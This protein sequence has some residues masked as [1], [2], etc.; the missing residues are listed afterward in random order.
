MIS[1]GICGGISVIMILNQYAFPAYLLSSLIAVKIMIWIVFGGV[2][3]MKKNCLYL[4]VLILSSLCLLFSSATCMAAE[5]VWC[6]VNKI[7]LDSSEST[8]QRFPQPGAPD[9]VIG[10]SYAAL[11]NL[12]LAAYGGNIISGTEYSVHQWD[13]GSGDYIGQLALS[14]SPQQHI[15]DPI[16]SIGVASNGD[17]LIS[18]AGGIYDGHSNPFPF[19][20]ARYDT[21]GN[22]V[23]N[24]S[25]ANLFILKGSPAASADAVF[26][27]SQYII[28]VEYHED[29]Q[30]FATDGTYVGAFGS[31]CGGVVGGIAVSGN[32]LYALDYGDGLRVYTLN[33]TSMPTYSHLITLPGTVNPAASF[34]GGDKLV[35]HGNALY[36]SDSADMA[37]YK[38]DFSGNLL[39]TYTVSPGG[40]LTILG[41]LTVVEVIPPTPTATATSTATPSFTPTDTP[42]NTPTPTHTPSNT[43]TPT[44]TATNVVPQ[45]F[46]D[47]NPTTGAPGLLVGMVGSATDQDGYITAFAWDILGNG[48]LGETIEVEGNPTN[49]IIS[50]SHTY[51]EPGLSYPAF[52]VWDDKNESSFAS[53]P[54]F[55]VPPIPT[56]TAT[57][58]PTPTATSTGTITPQPTATPTATSTGT[59]TPQPTATPTATSTGTITP[60]PTATST[61]TPTGTITPPPTATS[62]PT[63]TPV[64]TST[65]T[66]TPNWT[67]THTH[68][69]T[70]TFTP[71]PIASFDLNGDY[72][73]DKLDLLL[74][75]DAMGTASPQMDFDQNGIVDMA[76]V[77][78]LALEWNRLLPTP[79][80]TYTPSWTPTATYTHTPTDTPTPTPTYAIIP[81]LALQQAVRDAINKQTGDLTQQDLESLIE[82]AAFQKGIQRLEGLQYC[83]N[84]ERLSVWGNSI[85]D[86]G[87]LG[88]LNALQQ[89]FLQENQIIDLQPLVDNTGLGSGDVINIKDNPLSMTA[90]QVQVPALRGRGVTV[91]TE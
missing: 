68:T 48:E 45:V 28:G 2:N 60:Q 85:S 62:T 77:L 22:W 4:R 23:V 26:V 30:M 56:H 89:L 34:F 76:D 1:T 29:I 39:A 72:R 54:L 41:G 44:Q 32:V 14:P 35:S 21:S 7:S 53:R 87:P 42:T 79:T 38:L 25:H 81:D 82:L 63:D 90:Q 75:I 69:P 74:I 51:F 20:V 88:S 15:I 70:L 17:L 46:L 19:P 49:V 52:Y 13:G 65:S 6:S 66:P 24:Y 83:V 84:M 10:N 40:L 78:R 36:V 8:A 55:I 58:S 3:V 50:C 5:I 47:M 80:L 16:A 91:I 18:C 61:A 27:A 43:A 86:L 59:I 37:W 73:I 57:P 31:E 12:N 67:L 64:P 71:I 9:L 11:G 33:G